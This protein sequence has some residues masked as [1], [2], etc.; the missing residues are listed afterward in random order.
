MKVNLGSITVDDQTRR[1]IRD[2]HGQ[3][4]LATRK[5][6][7]DLFI[8]MAMADLETVVADY[9]AEERAT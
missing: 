5:E 2:R 1:A 3:R 6:V 8:A 9:E 7:K 4:G